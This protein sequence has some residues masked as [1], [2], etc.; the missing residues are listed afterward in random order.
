MK[1]PTQAPRPTRSAAPVRNPYTPEQVCGTGFQ[2]QRAS[3][4]AG[5]AVYQL[6]NASTGEN[7]VV[8]MKTAEV[9]KATP[10]SATLEVQGGA[11]Q[12]DR[13]EYEYY[14]GPV[15]LPAKGKCV[16]YHGRVGG[17]AASADWG[18]CG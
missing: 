3:T 14:A 6:Y 8:T 17:A 2:V 12:T 1:P 7:C 9:G 4:M 13:G 5:G 11:S 10:V 18:N 16:R 15:K